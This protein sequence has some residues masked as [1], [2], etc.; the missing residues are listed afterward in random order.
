M[1]QRLMFGIMYLIGFTPWDGHQLPKRLRELAETPSPLERRALDIG[2]G[3]GDS[4]IYLATKGWTVT[5]VDFVERA[6]RTAR[7]K[8]NAAHVQVRFV[9]ADATQLRASGVDGEFQ[10]LVD[11]GCFHG[12][13]DAARTAY[14]RAVTEVAAP[15]ARLVLAAFCDD[16]RRRGPRGVGRKEIEERF[17]GDW[18]LLASEEDPAASTRPGDPVYVY[19]LQRRITNT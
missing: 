5:A 12:L 16:R 19:E 3:T 7:G 17:A 2:C 4:S 15:N 14:V 6:L 18:N 1:L 9:R 8:A 13:D 10:L 11:N